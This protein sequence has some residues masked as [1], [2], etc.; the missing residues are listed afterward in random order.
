MPYY[1][2]KILA[3]DPQHYKSKTDLSGPPG[4][5][6]LRPAGKALAG[7]AVPRAVSTLHDILHPNWPTLVSPLWFHQQIRFCPLSIKKNDAQTETPSKG[8]VKSLST[9]QDHDLNE[10][11][12]ENLF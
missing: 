3:A 12:D 6:A 10:S 1:Y 2:F 4:C 9:S 11:S 7:F 8:W 5:M